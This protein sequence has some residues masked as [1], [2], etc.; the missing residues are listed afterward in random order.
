MKK[1]ISL[2]KISAPKKQTNNIFK[3]YLNQVTNLDSFLS[4]SKIFI[5]KENKTILGS[6]TKI[7]ENCFNLSINCLNKNS[8]N[9]NSIKL[10]FYQNLPHTTIRQIIPYIFKYPKTFDDLVFEQVLNNSYSHKVRL[11][12]QKWIQELKEKLKWKNRTSTNAYVK[13]KTDT[14][15]FDKI[16]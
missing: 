14:K 7:D 12:Y 1:K 6:I 9:F 11:R 8:G 3:L 13:R 16:I 4:Q 10:G 5:F 15:Y 2:L